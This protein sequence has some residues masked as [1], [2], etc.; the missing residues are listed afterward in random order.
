M[1]SW[2]QRLKLSGTVAQTFSRCNGSPT[3][4]DQPV[5]H[6]AAIMEMQV[7]FRYPSGLCTPDTICSWA[8]SSSSSSYPALQLRI[9]TSSYVYMARMQTTTIYRVPFLSI[10]PCRAVNPQL[11]KHLFRS[12]KSYARSDANRAQPPLSLMV[13]L[14]NKV[15]LDAS[16]HIKRCCLGSTCAQKC[17]QENRLGISSYRGDG[18]PTPASLARW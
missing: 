11:S 15:T 7:R 8:V 17:L 4:I 10:A 1:L 9:D 14:F 12:T 3:R 16:H 6:S 5:W 18:T 2:S 13:S